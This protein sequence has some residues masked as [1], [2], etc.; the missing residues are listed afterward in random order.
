VAAA[1]KKK[2]QQSRLPLLFLPL[3]LEGFVDA[4][5]FADTGC[6]GGASSDICASFSTPKTNLELQLQS[7]AKALVRALVAAAL[8]RAPTPKVHDMTVRQALG[9]EPMCIANG[10]DSEGLSLYLSAE[11]YE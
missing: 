1:L 3:L 4:R 9:R 10:T 7:T 8:R 2:L 5:Q 11:W 6:R